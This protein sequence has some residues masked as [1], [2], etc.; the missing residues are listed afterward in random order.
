M[1]SGGGRVAFD[2][3]LR[4]KLWPL[5]EARAAITA[6]LRLSDIA[7]PSLDDAR[8]LTGLDDTAANIAWF[9]DLGV[10]LIA[11]KCGGDGMLLADAEGGTW[12]LPGHRVDSVDATGAGDC[13]DGAFLAELARG[14]KPL[15]AAV[16]AN[17]AAALTTTGYGAVAP[18]PR[19]RDVESFQIGR[20]HG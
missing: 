16:Y 3:N 8:G 14:V 13:F 17:A 4:L 11:L 19:R 15:D 7:L 20:T 1:R 9:R 5:D 6:A 18:I 2:T 10:P 12:R